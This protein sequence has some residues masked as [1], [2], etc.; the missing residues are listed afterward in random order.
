MWTHSVVR[1]SNPCRALSYT[2]KNNVRTAAFCL[3]LQLVC[4]IRHL[5][6]DIGN[7]VKLFTHEECMRSP[8]GWFPTMSGGNMTVSVHFRQRS[9]FET[10]IQDGCWRPFSCIS[11]RE[12]GQNKSGIYDWY[13]LF[14]LTFRF[15][16]KFL[17][18]L[19]LLYQNPVENREQ[20][21][22]VLSCPL[23]SSQVWFVF[24]GPIRQ[25]RWPL[26]GWYFPSLQQLHGYHTCTVQ[27]S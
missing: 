9:R 23:S 15:G 11:S 16:G 18:L 8:T 6:L 24:F 3:K 2:Y 19:P 14:W 12:R 22:N 17:L 21:P 20:V 13:G 26:N 27:V 1:M 10:Q 5:N 4:K 25:Q 7:T